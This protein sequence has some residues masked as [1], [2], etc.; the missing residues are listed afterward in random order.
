ME[1][2]RICSF[3]IPSCKLIESNKGNKSILMNELVEI[4]AQLNQNHLHHVLNRLKIQQY[5][6]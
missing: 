4:I 2:H 3:G 1:H 6:K 5:N